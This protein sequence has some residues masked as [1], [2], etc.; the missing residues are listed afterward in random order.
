MSD[1]YVIA[2]DQGHLRIYAERRDP[3]QHKPSLEAVEAV[4]FP[5]GKRPYFANDTSPQG[6]FPGAGTGGSR[7]PGMS[8][9]ERL[10]MQ[11][12]N[13]TRSAKQLAEE[14]ETFLVGHPGATWDFAAGPDIH[15]A[16]L[17]RISPGARQR[18]R[19]ALAKDLVK[20]RPADL[21]A[22]F[23]EAEQ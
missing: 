1:H 17:E 23:A 19:R 4:D 8:I 20:H 12:E 3:N 7:H 10:P 22:Q 16:V 6:R 21:L 15:H 2:L 9:D 11:E 13:K 14:V 18:L 5:N